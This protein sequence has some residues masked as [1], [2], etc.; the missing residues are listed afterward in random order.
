M[1]FRVT[2]PPAEQFSSRPGTRFTDLRDVV[3]LRGNFASAARMTGM[4]T[5][6]IPLCVNDTVFSTCA[7][8]ISRPA[9]CVT[10]WVAARADV[11]ALTQGVLSQSVGFS[12]RSSLLS[13]SQLVAP[14]PEPVSVAR[15]RVYAGPFSCLS[16]GIVCGDGVDDI[17]F[18]SM[19]PKIRFFFGGLLQSRNRG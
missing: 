14:G 6:P 16:Q 15:A 9:P 3:S 2:R 10:V 1:G 11:A 7:C 12:S 4:P 13:Q 8:Y 18:C 19:F 17:F 5:P